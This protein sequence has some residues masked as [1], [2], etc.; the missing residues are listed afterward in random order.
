MFGYTKFLEIARNNARCRK[1]PNSFAKITC[2]I[3]DPCCGEFLI[4][5][6]TTMTDVDHF[7]LT[8][9]TV[10]CLLHFLGLGCKDGSCKSSF[11]Y[12]GDFSEDAGLE[13]F[14]LYLALSPIIF[15]VILFIQE[16]RSFEI[17]VSKL[18]S[19]KRKSSVY[20][21]PTDADVANEKLIVRRANDQCK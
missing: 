2:F 7:Y 4:L 5:H 6:S 13:E 14:L 11:P 21:E 10:L 1:L 20:T 18:R 19:S 17:L 12:L 8:I 3:G 16:N 15:L 9:E